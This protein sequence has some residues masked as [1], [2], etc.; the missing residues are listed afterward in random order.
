MIAILCALLIAEVIVRRSPLFG[1]SGHWEAHIPIVY[2]GNINRVSAELG[3]GTLAKNPLITES[4]TFSV[5][6]RFEKL[7]K[8]GLEGPSGNSGPVSAEIHC[9]LTDATFYWAVQ[10]L[11]RD[12]KESWRKKELIPI[13][14]GYSVRQKPSSGKLARVLDAPGG[15]TFLE[16]H[17]EFAE[18]ALD[19]TD[20]SI[21]V[22]NKARMTSLRA[23][24]RGACV[25]SL[26]NGR[27]EVSIRASLQGWKTGLPPEVVDSF[28]ARVQGGEEMERIMA[29]QRYYANVARIGAVIK[30]EYKISSLDV[31]GPAFENKAL[32]VEAVIDA[33]ER[34][35]R[36]EAEHIGT[37]RLNL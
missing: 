10:S 26:Q 34:R 35:C 5:H 6:D 31:L 24:Q 8:Q 12:F 32:W 4:L 30:I 11:A 23:S 20:T 15:D 9:A 36:G 13:G 27:T 7:A 2:D 1:V 21:F 29:D 18:G 33:L 19:L 22:P 14:A 16:A 28:V 3:P 25:L 17:P 37:E